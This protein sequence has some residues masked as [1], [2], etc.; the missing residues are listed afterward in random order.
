MV[1]SV[2]PS[3]DARLLAW[4]EDTTGNE[5]YTLHVKVERELAHQRVGAP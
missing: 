4:S 2:E 1:S 5:H 3:P